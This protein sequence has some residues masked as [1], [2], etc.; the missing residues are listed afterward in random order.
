MLEKMN[1]EKGDDVYDVQVS[2][3]QIKSGGKW[4]EKTSAGK[5]EKKASSGSLETAVTR[6]LISLKKWILAGNQ[7]LERRGRGER[8]R[9]E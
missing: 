7:V 6:N 8:E 3:K 1:S 5:G 2:R 4:G 9:E